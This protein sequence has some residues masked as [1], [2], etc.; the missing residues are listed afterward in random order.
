MLAEAMAG[1]TPI[2]AARSGA[3]P[4]VIDSA[5]LLF[6]PG[7]W[8]GLARLLDNGPLG[9]PPSN[10]PTRPDLVELYS[11]EAYASRIAAAYRRVLA[12]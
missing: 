3:V 8:M 11:S 7:D 4:E 1:E 5:G 2:V 10:P 9:K 12:S 6:E